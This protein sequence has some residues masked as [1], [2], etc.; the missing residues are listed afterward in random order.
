MIGRSLGTPGHDLS[1]AETGSVGLL[2]ASVAS[3]GREPNGSDFPNFGMKAILPT[4]AGPT[5]K[6]VHKAMNQ[7]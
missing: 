1:M 2:E 7:T 4:T 3:V 6:R 5:S